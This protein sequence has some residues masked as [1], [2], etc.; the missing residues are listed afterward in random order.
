MGGFASAA[1][2]WMPA[3]LAYRGLFVAATKPPA[4]RF[5][6]AIEIPGKYEV[7]WIC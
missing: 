6:S 3:R 1:I 7:C 4:D 2:N 5:D